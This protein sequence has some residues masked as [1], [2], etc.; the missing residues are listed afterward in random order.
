LTLGVHK[1]P[2]LEFSPLTRKLGLTIDSLIGAD[3]VL[4]D[5]S[6]VMV[7]AEEHSDLF[8]AIRGGGG[9]FVVVTSF[10]FR[11]H[12]V[13]TVLAGPTLWSLD[14]AA[15]VMRWYREFIISAPEN[16]NGFF[17]FLTVPPLPS[18]PQHLHLQRMCGVVWCYAGP[19]EGSD[20]VFKPIRDFGRRRFMGSK[21]CLSRLYR[22]RPTS[23]IR[24]V[25][26]GTGKVTLSMN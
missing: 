19:A 11:L 5:S 15:D 17:A 1:I 18:L 7:S 10:L 12:P 9:N 24:R 20:A 4:A 13:K 14:K 26:I 16:L 22:A 25:C 8:W 21:R 2:F 23:S 6:F 3:M